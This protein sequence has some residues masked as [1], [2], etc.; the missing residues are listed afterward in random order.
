MSAWETC[1][2]STC[3]Q[4][5]CCRETPTPEQWTCWYHGDDGDGWRNDEE[6]STGGTKFCPPGTQARWRWDQ[7]CMGGWCGDFPES[8]CCVTTCWAAGW[9]DPG[10]VGS[11]EVG[12]GE[13]GSGE[14]GSGD[15]HGTYQ[16]PAGQQARPSWD[17]H[18][19]GDRYAAAV[20]LSCLAR[21]VLRALAPRLLSRSLPPSLPPFLLPTPPPFRFC[22]AT[23]CH[24]CPTAAGTQVHGASRVLRAHVR[25][26]WLWRGVGMPCRHTAPGG[27][28]SVLVERGA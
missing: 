7:H 27:G 4:H 22:C 25:A 5:D 12:S 24:P 9:R 3:E 21:R 14:G 13:V 20:S 18:D 2:G 17:M 11:G 26:V 28:A 15:S 23:L 10:E 16:C 8:E 6:T 1:S 19:C